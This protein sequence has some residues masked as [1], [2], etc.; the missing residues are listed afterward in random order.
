MRQWGWTLIERLG[1][2]VAEG[3][4]RLYYGALFHPRDTPRVMREPF[5]EAP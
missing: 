1:E 2:A 3:W 5:R 4:A